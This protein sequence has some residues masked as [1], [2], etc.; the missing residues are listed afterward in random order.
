MRL[1]HVTVSGFRGYRDR[2]RINLAPGFTVIDGRNGV[3]KST[4]FDAV[5]YALTGEL[6]KYG[7]AKAAGQTVADYLRWRGAGSPPEERAVEVGFEHEGK[8]FTLKR[9]PIESPPARSLRPLRPPWLILRARPPSRSGSSAPPPS[10][11]TST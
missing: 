11:G 6:T 8:A 9:T 1:T 5:E 4:I 2:V 10:Y 3:G 7:E